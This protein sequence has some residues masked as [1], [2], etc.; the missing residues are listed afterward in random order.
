MVFNIFSL[1]LEYQHWQLWKPIYLLGIHY[2][3]FFWSFTFLNMPDL[4]LEL[5][6]LKHLI[7]SGINQCIKHRGAKLIETSSCSQAAL[8][9]YWAGIWVH[10][11]VKVFLSFKTLMLQWSAT[12]YGGNYLYPYVL[13]PLNSTSAFQ[14]TVPVFSLERI[15]GN[16]L[17]WHE[18]LI[19]EFMEY[20]S[21][22]NLPVFRVRKLLFL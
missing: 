10:V 19:L 8:Y 14:L 5:S 9:L 17:P 3:L 16:R 18:E 7:I 1:H 12:N 22:L 21:Q 6:C 11:Q 2:N 20:V 13:T 4:R 15:W